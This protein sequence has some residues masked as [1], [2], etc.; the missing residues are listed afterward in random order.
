MI[1]D[2]KTLMQPELSSNWQRAQLIALIPVHGAG[3]PVL[4]GMLRSGEI[5]LSF[6]SVLSGGFSQCW[7]AKRA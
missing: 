7:H 4:M 2:A 6:A 3:S 5:K 1:G